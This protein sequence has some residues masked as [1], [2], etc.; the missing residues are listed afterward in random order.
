[1]RYF[2]EEHVDRVKVYWG[3]FPYEKALRERR[4]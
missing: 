4:V 2:G 3:T 1:L